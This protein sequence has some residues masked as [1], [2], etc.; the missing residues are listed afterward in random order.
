MPYLRLYSPH[1]SLEQK[2]LIG[3]K[4]IDIT[5]RAFHL[6]AEQRYRTSIQFITRCQVRQPAGSQVDIASDADFTLEVIGHNL[7]EREKRAFA[8]EAGTMLSGFV[9]RSLPCKIASLVGIKS[10]STPRVAFQFSE[11]SPAVSDPF[12]VHSERRAA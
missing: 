9:P 4:L 3:Q 8:E 6:R 5:L 1:L 12:L 11:L 2:Q 10:D 7:T